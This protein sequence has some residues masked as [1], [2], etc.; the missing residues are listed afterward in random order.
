M[1]RIFKPLIVAC[2]VVVATGFSVTLLKGEVPGKQQKPRLQAAS[3]P[4]PAVPVAEPMKTPEPGSP[5]AERMAAFQERVKAGLVRTV[6]IGRPLNYIRPQ[7]KKPDFVPTQI[8]PQK[9]ASGE[10]LTFQ[11]KLSP[12]FAAN[13]PIP[14]SRGDHFAWLKA[15]PNV[16]IFGWYGTVTGA[17]VQ[18]DSS[19]IVA[20]EFHP[21]TEITGMRAIVRDFVTEKYHVFNGNLNLID[22]D[23]GISNPALQVVQPF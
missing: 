1:R 17:E 16:R 13:D 20:I 21:K 15:H 12:A 7:V 8:V 10:M 6:R 2:C 18:D 11:H 14:T 22:T 9:K 5:D 23:A 3:K 19:V 4:T